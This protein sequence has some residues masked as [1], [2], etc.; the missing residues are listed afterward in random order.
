MRPLIYYEPD[1]SGLG[2]RLFDVA[3]DT[4][5]PWKDPDCVSVSRLVLGAGTSKVSRLLLRRTPG[6]PRRGEVK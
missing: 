2:R 1:L 4:L 3:L 5:L 6:L